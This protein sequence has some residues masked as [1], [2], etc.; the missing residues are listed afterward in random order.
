[1]L[2]A[3]PSLLTLTLALA[4]G[5]AR[6]D[7]PA[8]TPTVDLE[9]GL[10][11]T[12]RNDVRIPGDSGTRFSLAEGAFSPRSAT[13]FRIQ[14]GLALG[15]HHLLATAAPLRVDSDGQGGDALQFA[16]STFTPSSTTA[17]YRFDTY[18]LTYRYA[19]VRGGRLD[20]QVGATALLRAAEIRLQQ[21]GGAS[22]SKANLGLVPLLS[23]RAAWRVVG[24][25][26]L[27]LD[28][29][30]LAAPQGRAEDALLAVELDTGDLRFRVGYRVVEGGADNRSV[31]NFALF[32]HVG[33]GMTYAF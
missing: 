33:A 6:A 13:Y 29:D 28:G 15:R 25:F 19:V 4:L 26:A 14:G 20:L 32:H 12:G 24:P 8:F 17:H 30:A 22:A 16:G 18:R 23:L 31:Y 5:D 7:V 3:R 2:L 27:V 10:L 11:S 9:V 1:V 21:V